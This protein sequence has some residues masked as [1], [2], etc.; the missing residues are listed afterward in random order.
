MLQNDL[1]FFTIT[2]SKTPPVF[3][4]MEA[5]DLIQDYRD[6]S[7]LDMTFV[8]ARFKIDEV[9]SIRIENLQ[10]IMKISFNFIKTTLLGGVI[11]LLPIVILATVFDKAIKIVRM[12]ADP[13]NKLLPVETI[14]GIAL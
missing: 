3:S 10:G 13:L 1:P 5:W 11:F 14:G 12:L 7:D 4:T 2:A 9:T 8:L 6:G